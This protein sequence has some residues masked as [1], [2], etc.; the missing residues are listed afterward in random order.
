MP[1]PPPRVAPLTSATLPANGLLILILLRSSS[2]IP[3]ARDQHG[4]QHERS[5]G[6]LERPERLPE[7]E[8]RE[9]HRHERLDRG[10]HR[11]ARRT[12]A[13]QSREQEADCGDRRDEGEAGQPAPARD[14]LLA[15][16][17]LAQ[18]RRA[19]REAHRRPAADDRRQHLR[20]DA[21]RERVADEDVAAVDDRRA[22]PQ[23]DAHGVERADS[24]A[25]Q[26]Q[27][28]SG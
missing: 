23:R 5:A 3:I 22:E 28:Q 26:H 8:E 24:G 14:R 6:E 13:P 19:G 9:Q 10:E 15:G 16:P 21:P 17:Q 25:R 12:D 18:R 1:R 20:P 27:Q 11:R 7:H 4:G 2:R